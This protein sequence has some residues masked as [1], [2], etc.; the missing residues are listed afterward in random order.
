[1]WPFL[2]QV[3][4]CLESHYICNKSGATDTQLYF[5]PVFFFLDDYVILF[6]CVPSILPFKCLQVSKIFFFS[7]KLKTFIQEGS[8]NSSKVTVKSFI[9]LQK[10]LFLFF[11]V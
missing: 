10:N 4:W 1:M 8:V 9:M 11:G 6:L 5:Y 7:K 2:S 3:L